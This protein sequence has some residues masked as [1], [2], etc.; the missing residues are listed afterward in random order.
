MK[1]TLILLSLVV[2]TGCPGIKDSVP[3]TEKSDVTLR[4]GHVCVTVQPH[5]DEKIEA[6]SIY[7]IKLPD[8][9][10]YTFFSPAESIDASQCL[11][12]SGYVFEQHVAY[13]YSAKLTSSRRK[14]TGEWPVS[15][16]FAVEFLLHDSNGKVTIE[17][18]NG[19]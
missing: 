12:N 11:P 5:K 3:R 4:D 19:R 13:H 18:L 15:R 7:R 16:E 1:R 14:Q 17:E 2:L 6:I 9:R 8:D 10:K